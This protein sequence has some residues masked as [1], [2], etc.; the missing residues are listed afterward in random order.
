MKIKNSIFKDYKVTGSIFIFVICLM[1]FIFMVLLSGCFVIGNAG[2]KSELQV[3]HEERWGIYLLDSRTR[4]LSLVYGSQEK[5]DQL[6]LN[7][8]ATRFAFSKFIDGDELEDTEICVLNADGS[9]YS[10]LTDNNCIDVYPRWSP[11]SLNILFLTD[12]DGDMDIYIMDVQSGDARKFYDSGSHDADIDWKGS[13]ITFTSE[14]CIWIMDCDG[15]NPRR[16][17][18]PPGAGE[19]GSSVLPFGDYDPRLSYDEKK[20]VFERMVD[21]SSEHGNY[22]IF[23]VDSD[24]SDV[25]RLTE[26]GYTQ[27]LANWSK[28]GEKILYMVSAMGSEGKFDIFLM[29]SDGTDNKNITP[30]YFPEDF[31]CHNPIF[32][33]DEDEIFF[34]GEWWAE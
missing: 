18:N 24:G 12:R 22:D 30:D 11:D 15:N 14:S 29:N 20:V 16:I 4:K 13:K 3:P 1:I 27:G 23:T 32:S 21:D 6:H 19:W 34:I 31:L 26:T 17:T 8:D 25:K 33:L 10:Q 9:G 2:N 5:I 28:N 7:Y